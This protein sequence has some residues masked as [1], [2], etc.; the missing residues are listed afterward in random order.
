MKKA[1]PGI[2]CLPK[3]KWEECERRPS[4]MEEMFPQ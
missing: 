2:K 1:E 3:L 4:E